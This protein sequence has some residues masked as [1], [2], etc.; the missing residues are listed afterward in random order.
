[1]L[2]V[3]LARI[4][5]LDR[6]GAHAITVLSQLCRGRRTRL[7]LSDVQADTWR[8]LGREGVLDE[9]GPGNVFAEWQ[10]AL[11]RASEL[12]GLRRE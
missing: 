12:L 11:D 1:V 8:G 10:R 5:C 3:R 6:R 9:V 2:I 7:L 4:P